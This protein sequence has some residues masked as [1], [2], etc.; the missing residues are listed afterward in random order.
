M[1]RTLKRSRRSTKRSKAFAHPSYLSTTKVA[2]VVAVVEVGKTRM[3]R[4][5][6]MSFRCELHARLVRINPLG[7]PTPK[8]KELYR[9][10]GHNRVK[11]ILS[12][13]REHRKRYGVKKK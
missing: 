8:D 2:V 1:G 12:A 5:R 13:R 9:W 11:T 6:M 7:V 4:K 10:R 3:K